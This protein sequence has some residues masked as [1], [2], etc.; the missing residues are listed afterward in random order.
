MVPR[1]YGIRTGRYKL[2]HFYHF[3]EWEFYDLKNDP[4]ELENLYNNPEFAGQIEKLKKGL[5]RL[6]KK[7][8]DDSNVDVMPEQ[9]QK[10]VRAGLK[11]E[12]PKPKG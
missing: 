2:M 10:D 12:N 11:V 6:R 3:D 1:Q 4:D 5:S 8:G 9:W 7:Y